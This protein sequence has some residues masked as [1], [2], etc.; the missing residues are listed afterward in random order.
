MRGPSLAP[1]QLQG[2]P[3]LPPGTL[4]GEAATYTHHPSREEQEALVR[5]TFMS[6]P[7]ALPQA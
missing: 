1:G 3:H 7:E 4:G 6:K 2:L 5:R